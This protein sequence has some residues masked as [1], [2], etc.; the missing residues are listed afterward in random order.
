M[1]KKKIMFHKDNAPSHKSLKAMEK[2]AQ[3]KFE[4]VAYNPYSS[5]L[6]PND[7]YLFPNLKRYL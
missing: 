7:Y 1:A 4:L 2:L 5:D 6:S 3:S